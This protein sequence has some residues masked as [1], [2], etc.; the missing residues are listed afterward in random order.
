M[1]TPKK[2]TPAPAAERVPCPE[3]Q[4]PTAPDDLRECAHCATTLCLG[5]L[6]ANCPL[7]SQG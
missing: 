5:C 6:C 3:C 4:N 7:R 2:P 1:S